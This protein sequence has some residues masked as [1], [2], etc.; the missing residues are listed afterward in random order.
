M[1]KS[2]TIIGKDWDHAPITDGAT[3]L[4]GI[5]ANAFPLGT[6]DNLFD[7][8][9]KRRSALLSVLL[10][11]TNFEQLDSYLMQARDC[12]EVY[13]VADWIPGWSSVAV[14]DFLSLRTSQTLHH[15]KNLLPE[16]TVFLVMAAREIDDGR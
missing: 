8:P 6:P 15:V 3:P 13:I 14:K 16:A 9:T 2:Y 5:S 4:I 7:N 12:D 1:K 11:F 10:S